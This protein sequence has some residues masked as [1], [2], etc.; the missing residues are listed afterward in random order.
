MCLI[1]RLQPIYDDISDIYHHVTACLCHITIITNIL[2]DIWNIMY[3]TILNIVW[4]SNFDLTK[5]EMG[6]FNVLLHV[7]ELLP[8]SQYVYFYTAV[9]LQFDIQRS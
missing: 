4:L 2:F 9:Y 6:R 3:Q 1:S 5:V 7:Y 8:F